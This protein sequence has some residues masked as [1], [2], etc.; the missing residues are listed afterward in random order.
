MEIKCPGGYH[1]VES[2]CVCGK[3]IYQY[4]DWTGTEIIYRENWSTPT[5]WFHKNDRT[6]KCGDNFI[7]RDEDFPIRH[8]NIRTVP[9]FS[10]VREEIKES[11]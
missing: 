9:D 5:G 2:F 8:F 4:V 10:I 1:T 3:T 11:N 7:E 6:F